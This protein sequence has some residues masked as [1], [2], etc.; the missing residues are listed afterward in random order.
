MGK[1]VAVLASML[2]G[3]LVA[4]YVTM[5]SFGKPGA[6]EIENT[7]NVILT[8]IVALLV[9][10]VPGA[11]VWLLDKFVNPEAWKVGLLVFVALVLC[12]AIGLFLG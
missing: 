1:I 9:F 6:N 4:F 2:F 7:R 8:M 12:G 10:L 11:L 3:G 5:L